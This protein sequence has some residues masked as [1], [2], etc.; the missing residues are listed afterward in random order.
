LVLNFNTQGNDKQKL[1][2]KYWCD[3]ET[4]DIVYGGSKGAAKSYT[5]CSLIFGDALIYPETHYFIA[6]K[7][8]NDLRKFTIPSIYEVL[9]HF[10][11]PEHYYKFNG[12]D[13]FFELYNGSKVFLLDAKY[14]PSDPHYYRFG[15]MQMTR[16]WIEEAGEF[17]EEAKN[18]LQA[19]IGRWK[20]IDYDLTPKLLQTCNP[21]K[22]YLYRDY[23]K[24]NK[25]GILEPHKRF[26]QALP[27]DNKMLPPEYIPN[28]LKILS[29]NEIERLL[30]GNWE[31]DDNPY[32]LFD[33]NDVLNL[34][35]NEFIQGT[36][37]KYLTADI[38]YEGSDRFVIGIWDGLVLEYIEAIDKIDETMVSKK[39]HDLRI[40]Y[41]IPI[42][43]VCY[44]ADGLKRFVRQSA[45]SGY[46][47]GAREFHNGGS[48]I[49]VKGKLENF[50]NLKAQCYYYLAEYVKDNRIYIK[51]KNWRKQII[52][53]LEQINKL[54]LADDGKIRLEPKDAI[55]ER[56][57]R[58]PD[59]ADI[60]QMRLLFELSPK[61]YMIGGQPQV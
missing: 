18:N 49:K 58:S 37:V 54:P 42:S 1:C 46:L 3:K 14:L 48:P 28:L 23:Y 55:R 33:Y 11:V 56:L 19:S 29:P 10:G 53:E 45:N 51:D 57:G 21:S 12:Q 32:A 31:Y 35:T 4:I 36:G 16:G 60:L 7:K 25:D 47:K 41:R 20:N 15:S 8:L 34:F 44:D 22:N 9:K 43:N 30:K 6:R 13:S 50:F 38:A 26:I 17:E 40:K 2:A 39:I 61:P 52:E 59:F 24:K 27:S 5:G